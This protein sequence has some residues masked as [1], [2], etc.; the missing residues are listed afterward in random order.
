MEHYIT[1]KMLHMLTAYL[2]TLLFVIR[3]GLDAVGKPG[4]RTTPLRWIPHANDTLL[5]TMAVVLVVLGGWNIFAQQ[6]LLVKVLLLIGYV[7]AGLFALKPKL[8]K[9]TRI[10]AAVLAL[11]Q[12]LIIF[13]V[14]FA[15]PF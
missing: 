9:R 8:P 14:A 13:H 6:W 11:L 7:V 12:L 4:W 15:K 2:T 3:L 10:I 5:I 1:F